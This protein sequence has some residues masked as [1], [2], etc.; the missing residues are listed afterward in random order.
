M[1]LYRVKG[2]LLE[3]NKN[4]IVQQLNC[5]T[6][7]AKGLSQTISNKYPYADVY[8]SRKKIPGK[9]VAVEED[10]GIPGDIVISV[11]DGPTIIGIYG[12]YAPSKPRGNET[13]ELRLQWFKECLHKIKNYMDNEKYT[14]IAFPYKIGCGL[15]GGDWLKY[16]KEIKRFA[17]NNKYD[18]YIYKLE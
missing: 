10:R 17:N 9:Y 12:Q 3:S 16:K 18:V 5:I 11:G 14:S 8:S 1:P 6:I 2:D 4:I 15:A 7:N 13:A